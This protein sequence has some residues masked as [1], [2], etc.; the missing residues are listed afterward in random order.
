M[1]NMDLFRLDV[2]EHLDRIEAKCK[3]WGVAMNKI[4][5]IMRN[6]DRPEMFIVMSTETPDGLK[7]AAALATGEGG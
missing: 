6:P 1:N 2:I 4:T 3:Q 5:L 7:I